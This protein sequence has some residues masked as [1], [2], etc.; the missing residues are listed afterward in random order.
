MTADP[1]RPAPPPPRVLHLAMLGSALVLLAV[2]VIL[3]ATRM[4]DLTLAPEAGRVVGLLAWGVTAVGLVATLVLQGRVEP[5][6]P[7]QEAG[8]WWE[9]QMPRLVAAWAV[10]EG[11]A[12]VGAVALLVSDNTLAAAAAGGTGLALL[13]SLP[14]SKYDA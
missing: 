7:E 10:A 4:Q 1:T 8:T 9:T 2:V 6:R 12:A 13:A 11:I 14:P 5:R 3:R